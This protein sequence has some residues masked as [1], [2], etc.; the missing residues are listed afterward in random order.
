MR[1]YQK[2]TLDPEAAPEA[3]ESTNSAESLPRR[4]SSNTCIYSTFI[5]SKKLAGCHAFARVW[6]TKHISGQAVEVEH[7]VWGTGLGNG[8]GLEY[9]LR[10]LHNELRVALASA[11]IF[12]IS[13]GAMNPSTESQPCL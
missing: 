8:L 10:G 6:Q 9:V 4:R 7:L 11:R 12:G 3:S 13:P 2:E 1:E 5:A